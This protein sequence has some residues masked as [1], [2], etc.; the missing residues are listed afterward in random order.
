[1]LSG[2][3]YEL[4]PLRSLSADAS[5]NQEECLAACGVSSY[6]ELNGEL[7]EVPKQTIQRA[8]RQAKRRAAEVDAVLVVTESFKEL[9]GNATRPAHNDLQKAR[10][11][12]FDAVADV[13]VRVAP[14]FCSTFGGSSNFLQAIFMA[15]PLV[16]SGAVDCLLIVCVDKKS[17]GESRFMSDAVALIGDGVAACVLGQEFKTGADAYELEYTKIVPFLDARNP[18]RWQRIILVI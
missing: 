10:N 14:V 18:G 17:A 13:G 4:G 5:A 2:I 6:S 11:A 1:M 12:I 3:S 16:E 7:I 9:V 15:K 8:L